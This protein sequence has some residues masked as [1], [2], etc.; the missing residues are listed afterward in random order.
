[1]KAVNSEEIQLMRMLVPFWKQAIMAI[2][3]IQEITETMEI[4]EI[5]ASMIY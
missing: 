1:M 2:Q 5:A 3:E 4:R